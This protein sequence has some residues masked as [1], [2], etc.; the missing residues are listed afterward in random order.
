MR[1]YLSLAAGAAL[2]LAGCTTSNGGLA[3]SGPTSTDVVAVDRDFDLKHGQTARLDGTGVTVSFVGVPEDSRCPVD[4]Q[5][6]WA[7]NGAVSLVVTDE[8]GGKTTV[9]LNTMLSPRSVRVSGYEIGLTG[10]RPDPK[11]SSPI[12]L[13]NYVATLRVT[14]P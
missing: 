10:L 1:A 13:A 9:I 4:V 5:C 11:Q 2:A 6:V 12:P 8:T 14:R 3:A 7:G